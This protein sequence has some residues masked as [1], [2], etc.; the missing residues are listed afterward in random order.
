MA[1]ILIAGEDFSCL[2]T[3]ASI[4]TGEGHQVTVVSDGME[5]YES[6]L[7]TAPDLLVLEVNMPIFNGFETCDMLR[8][9]PT[10]LDTLPI[11]LLSAEPIDV[12][13]M[14]QHSVTGQISKTIETYQLQ[15]MLVDN[16]GEKAGGES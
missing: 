14:E 15:E 8:S 4:I 5:A 1:H 3:I 13:K 2:D 6:A 9:D 16:L 7:A 11:I 12:R 10:F